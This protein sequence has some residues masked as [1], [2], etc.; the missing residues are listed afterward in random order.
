MKIYRLAELF[1]G[2][3]GIGLGAT[4]AQYAGSSIRPVFSI[5]RDPDA[6]A[7]YNANIDDCAVCQS[8]E[9]LDIG[10]MPE[11]D[12]LAFGFPC[13]DFSI[14]GKKMGLSGEYGPL[15]EY[16]VRVL[17][18]RKPALFLAENVAGLISANG[19]QAYDL[20]K[21]EL[22]CCGYKIDARLYRLE[23]YGVPQS[24]HRVLIVG[25]R[26]DLGMEFVPPAPTTPSR[27]V[28]AREALAKIPSD[29]PNHDIR[30]PS[31]MVR[32]R[33]SY[34][35]PG[36]NIWQAELPKHLKLDFGAFQNSQQYRR[37][38]PDRPAYTLTA[39]GGGGTQGFHFA[40]LR[41]LTNRERARLQTFP[42]DFVFHGN[43]ASVRRQ[44][45]MAV[46]PLA[47]KVFFERILECMARE[48]VA[49][50]EPLELPSPRLHSA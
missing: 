48:N 6:C 38:H 10:S 47:A 13:N 26:N 43:S 12:A 35:R 37:L 36:E 19:G 33:L 39:A 16:A 5:D 22:E 21:T 24:R 45:G 28:T 7:T 2:A 49:A 46:P 23:E 25:F 17:D 40:E 8:I 9:D 32:E 14:V 30:W 18:A 15:Y 31:A 20:I 27:P 50:T 4:V 42:D 41:A 3:G 29:A 34:I 1:G 11:F 44:I